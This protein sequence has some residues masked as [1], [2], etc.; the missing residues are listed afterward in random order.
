LNAQEISNQ[1]N[2]A[3]SGLSGQGGRKKYQ[4]IEESRNIYTSIF[5]DSVDQDHPIWDDVNTSDELRDKVNRYEREIDQHIFGNANFQRE[6]QYAAIVSM[7]KKRKLPVHTIREE[8]FSETFSPSMQK[9]HLLSNSLS[10]I[11]TKYK[12]AQSQWCYSQ[13]DS[14]ARKD[15]EQLV[16]DFSSMRMPP[17]NLVNEVLA[18]IH[19]HGGN[20]NVFNFEIT[21]PDADQLTF[22]NYQTYSFIPQLRDRQHGQPRSFTD[23]SSGEQTLLALAISIYQATESYVLPRLLLLD[24][25]DS[26]LHPS[27]SK[28]LLATL[29]EVF[30]D[31]GVPVILATHS[32]STVAL[33]PEDSVHV[34]RKES[35]GLVRLTKETP[36]EAIQVLSEGFIA[37]SNSGLEVLR[38]LPTGKL[39]ILTEGKNTLILKR[40]IELHQIEGVVVV[41]GCENRTGDS[42]IKTFYDILGA[43]RHEGKIL[44]V[45]DCDCT[46]YRNLSETSSLFRYVIPQNI[47]NSLAESGIENAFSEEAFEGFK[48]SH[49]RQ[50][51][52]SD[53]ETFDGRKRE[54]ASAMASTSE[55]EWFSHFDGLIEKIK[56]VC[57]V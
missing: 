30:V 14:G 34:L 18:T 6:A 31:R 37:L 51:D 43:I 47:S 8:E 22:N 36:G 25:V 29:N 57:T 24:E 53:W 26:S 17:W 40:L 48:V 52:G 19:R 1:T 49:H 5:G 10:V 11:F 21:T 55:L 41:E 16:A 27:M 7:L 23:L 35:L 44:C 45:W 32:P 50:S 9:E 28:A 54:F 13:F 4:L 38:L 15:R 56:S 39:G 3:W 12:V 42:Q 33:A 46:K 2:A 20:D